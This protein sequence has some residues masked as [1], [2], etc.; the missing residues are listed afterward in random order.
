MKFETR[1]SNELILNTFD[2]CRTKQV[3]E[4]IG[5]WMVNDFII[6]V[7]SLPL[8]VNVDHIKDCTKVMVRVSDMNDK[9]ISLK[10][11]IRFKHLPWADK[12]IL[13]GWGTLTPKELCDL[14]NYCIRIDHLKVFL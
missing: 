8:G 1:L 10:R 12:L 7:H 11:D 2:A 14:V 13:N 6:Y 9:P 5:S 3:D 4:W